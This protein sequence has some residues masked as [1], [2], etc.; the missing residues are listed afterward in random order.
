MFR[1][2]CVRMLA[3]V[4][5]LLLTMSAFAFA[6][7]AA[8][9][10]E[11]VK[12]SISV[13][14]NSTVTINVGEQYYVDPEGRTI[15]STSSSKKKFVSI[16]ANGLF[17]GLA[18]GTSKITV[19]YTDKSKFV[20]Y[21]QVLDPN[22]PSAVAFAEGAAIN[23]RIGQS[24]GLTPV[25]APSWAATAYT[26][27]SSKKGIAKVENGVVT[28]VK[29]GSCVITATTSNKLTASIT[30]NVLPNK[31]DN[32]SVAPTVSQIQSIGRN[33][34][35]LLKSVEILPNNKVA[36]EFFMLNGLGKSSQIV[37]FSID[38]WVRGIHLVNGFVKKSSA[39]T[40][41]H[42]PAV[43]K[44]TFPATALLTPNVDLTSMT[45]YDFYI[46]SIDGKLKYRL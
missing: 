15:K 10:S 34:T 13:Q 25:L 24:A 8:K 17:T 26:W 11:L 1:N 2:T 22:K 4:L 37:D 5:A 46:N 44:I 33:W 32:I 38:L 45:P 41:K 40:S 3:L 18:E 16:D 20:F 35:M 42:V 23:L 39:K 14:D 29:V 30:V 7:D 19:K 36:M 12:Q 43:V 6:E 9:G 27:K 21:V 28:G 31:A